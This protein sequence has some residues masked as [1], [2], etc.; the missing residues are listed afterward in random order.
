[1]GTHASSKSSEGRKPAII[2]RTRKARSSGAEARRLAALL[3]DP[4][5]RSAALAGV[6][7]E[8]DA[9]ANLRSAAR[10]L[11][12]SRPTLLKW[13]KQIPELDVYLAKKKNRRASEIAPGPAV[14]SPS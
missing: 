14:E 11:N 4:A 3:S 12:V 9:A 10:H 6:Y 5:Q 1:M 7:T 2:R 13:R 8:I